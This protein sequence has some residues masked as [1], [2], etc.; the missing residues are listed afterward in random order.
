M[1]RPTYTQTDHKRAFEEFVQN[2]NY[3]SCAKLIGCNWETVRKWSDPEF[4]CLFAC[5][6]HGW[7]KLLEERERAHHARMELLNQGNHDPVDHDRA[8][9]GELART[10]HERRTGEYLTQVAHVEIVRS[11]IERLQHWEYLWSKVY[12]DATGMVADWRQFRGIN[13]AD[14]LEIENKLREH[15]RVG[16]HATSLEQCVRMLATIQEHID[17]LQGATRR[18]PSVSTSDGKIAS[19]E[20]LREMRK[21]LRNTPKKKLETVVTV[22]RSGEDE[23]ETA[24]AS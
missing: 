24:A 10:D 20:E 1:S 18:S 8:I 19:L 5:P 13:G 7:N 11:D 12:Y 22:L 17:K 15:L 2:R 9:R 3:S 6:W 21:M 4:N 16:L 14:Q 23:S